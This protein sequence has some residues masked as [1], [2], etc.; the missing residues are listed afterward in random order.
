MYV[1]GGV[2]VVGGVVVLPAVVDVVIGVEV[3]VDGEAVDAAA[4]GVDVVDVAVLVAGA[5]S[6]VPDDDVVG[7]PAWSGAVV[8]VGA[9]ALEPAEPAGD[10]DTPPPVAVELGTDVVDVGSVPVEVVTV[11][12]GPDDVVVPAPATSLSAGAL[13]TD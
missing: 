10:V 1:V 5:A 3:V 7:V 8:V 9:G 12:D 2:F 11:E 6:R 4:V 13:L